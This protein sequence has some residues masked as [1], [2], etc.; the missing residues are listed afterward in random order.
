MVLKKRNTKFKPLYKKILSLRENVQNRP[1]I[2]RF[3]K[4]KWEKL[5]KFYSRKLK[6][7][8]KFKP[9]NQNLYIISRY[10]NYYHSYRKNYKHT[11]HAAK[12]FRLFLGNMR[13]KSLKKKIA[14]VKKQNHNIPTQS[15]IT[16]IEKRL[17]LILF[18]AKFC[19]S[20]RNAQQCISHGKVLIN[21]KVT[22]SFT[23]LIKEGD[24]ISIKPKHFELFESNIRKAIIW[25]LPPKHLTINYKTMQII[26]G[27][28]KNI[29][30]SMLFLFPLNL[31]KILVNLPRQ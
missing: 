10:P 12:S 23:H 26:V 2:L 14:Q 27:D 29:N 5:I 21:K 24:L 8:K 19:Y 30:T 7:Y 11:L 15:F 6:W 13:K 17:D 4:K 9:K 22:T 18:R 31:D 3:R 16:Q 28:L 1:K 20:L 25:P